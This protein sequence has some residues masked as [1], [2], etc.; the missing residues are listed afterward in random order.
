M[1]HFERKHLIVDQKHRALLL[2]PH[3]ADSVGPSTAAL[4]NDPKHYMRPEL[5]LSASHPRLF[6]IF[7]ADQAPQINRDWSEIHSLSKALLTPQLSS[8]FPKLLQAHSPDAKAEPSGPAATF[9]QHA[10]PL[11]LFLSSFCFQSLPIT[12][13]A[14]SAATEWL[15][16]H[17]FWIRAHLLTWAY[18]AG[19]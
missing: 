5:Q 14:S 1:L 9:P 16:T 6:Q 10:K 3:P 4:T 19:H 8:P 13:K 12:S 2:P 11:L 18:K 15:E 17:W 7:L